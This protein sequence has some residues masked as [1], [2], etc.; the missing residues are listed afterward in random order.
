MY[1]LTA[2][3][4]ISSSLSCVNLCM[5][6]GAPR[7]V[8][9][10]ILSCTTLVYYPFVCEGKMQGLPETTVTPV[11]RQGGVGAGVLEMVVGKT[12]WRKNKKNDMRTTN[13]LFKF[14]SV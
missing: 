6:Q 3:V 1:E 10:F 9:R 4:P 12:W 7:S 11:C 13:H 5:N 14:K 2:I 8:I